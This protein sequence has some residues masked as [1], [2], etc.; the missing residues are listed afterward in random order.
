MDDLKSFINGVR[1]G[2]KHLHWTSKSI[3]LQTL[4]VIVDDF[5]QN[6]TLNPK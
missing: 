3:V 5:I 1:G 2:V 6:L 4:F